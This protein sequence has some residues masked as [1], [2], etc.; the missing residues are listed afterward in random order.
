MKHN[1]LSKSSALFFTGLFALGMHAQ[2]K[3]AKKFGRGTELIPCGTTINQQMLEQKYPGISSTPSFENWI[4]GKIAAKNLQKSNMDD[5][6]PIIT[7]PIVV[8]VVHNGD[9]VG[10]NENISEAQILSQI[11]VLNQDYRRMANTPGFNDNPVGADMEIQFCLAKRAPDGQNTTGIIRHQMDVADGW[12]M[13]DANEILKPQTQ[14][15]PEQ[16]LNIWVVDWVYVEVFGF[17]T[18]LAGFSTFPME[19][20]LG[21]LDDPNLPDTQ[22]VP[23]QDGVVLGHRYFGSRAIFPEGTYDEI[24]GRDKGRSASHEIGHYLGLRHIWGDGGCDVDDY[25]EDTPVAAG[26]NQNCTPVDSCPDSEGADMIENYMDYTPDACMNIFTQDQKARMAAVLANS[27]RRVSLATS[28]A[29]SPAQVFDNDGSLYINGLN[30]VNCSNTFTPELK[31]TNSGNN[32]LTSATITYTLNNGEP[33][34]INWTGNLGQDDSDVITLP[35]MALPSGAYTF[36]ADIITVN[37]GE[38][39]YAENDLKTAGFKIIANSQT[40]EVTVTIQT[41]SYGSET[42]WGIM[43]SDQQIIT[44][45]G[46]YNDSEIEGETGELVTQIVPLE[47][48][49]CYTFFIYDILS[50]GMCC[51]YGEGYYTVSDAN[52]NVFISGGEFGQ[53]ETA[54]FGVDITMGTNTPAVTATGIK[55]YPNP[56]SNLITVDISKNVALP[57]GYT[58]YNNLGQVMDKG[59]VTAYNQQIDISSYSNGVYFINFATATGTKTLQFIK[60]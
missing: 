33:T 21:G 12:S 37:G 29:C 58:I 2:E 57:Q 42:I 24:G 39:A 18:E 55:L 20:G 51:E 40:E 31:I 26:A 44:T 45:G 3:P 28:N 41:D 34:E 25:C 4:A 46:P 30:M 49:Q 38:D 11:E 7:I 48:G 43:D 47:S 54:T 60:Y 32:I 9:A 23:N 22:T 56:A 1:K 15:D 50:D 16:Y 13:T 27:P 10:M 8:H 36:T 52:G 17:K 53:Y 35:L 6:N 19:S 5:P 14:W 59:G